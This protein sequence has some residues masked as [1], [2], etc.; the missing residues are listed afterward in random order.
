VKDIDGICEI[1]TPFIDRHSDN[2][3]IHIEE[4]G[5]KF[6]LTDKGYTISDLQ[7]N[8]Y[9][10]DTNEKRQMLLCIL[11]MFGINLYKNELVINTTYDDFSQ[12]LHNIIQ[13]ILYVN[14]LFTI[15]SM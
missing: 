12:R 1:T 4:M 3:Q 7:T 10:F 14:S 5:D 8:G 6:I 13:A 15:K 9:D 11:N 2:I